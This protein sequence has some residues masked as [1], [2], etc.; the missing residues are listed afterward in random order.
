LKER[1][2]ELDNLRAKLEEPE[3]LPNRE[4]FEKLCAPLGPLV[5]LGVGD[6]ATIRQVLRKIGV[7]HLVVAP[8]DDGGWSFKGQ[9][10]SGGLLHRR[11]Q[12][13]PPDSPLRSPDATVHRIRL[14][15][16]SRRSNRS[17]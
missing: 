15:R 8:T 7:T 6:P 5:G 14:R 1:Q 17:Q 10:D 13:A 11:V 9:G 4:E 12:A 2:Q 16:H 3:P